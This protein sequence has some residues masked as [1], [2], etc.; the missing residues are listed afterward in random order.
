MTEGKWY[1]GVITAYEIFCAAL[2]GGDGYL[3][4]TRN[5]NNESHDGPSCV[6]VG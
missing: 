1:L 4:I 2:E 5:K 6:R 3:A